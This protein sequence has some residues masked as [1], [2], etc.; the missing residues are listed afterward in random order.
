VVTAPAPA[1]AS[2]PP[3]VTAPAPAPAL[4]PPVVTAPVP[5]P[6]IAAPVPPPSPPLDARELATRAINRELAGDHVGALADLRAALAL[7]RDPSRRESLTNLI[8]LLDPPR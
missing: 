6:V 8:R 2:P 3:V 4:P 1:P 7:E 5:P